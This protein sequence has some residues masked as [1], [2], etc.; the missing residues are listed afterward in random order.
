MID[1]AVIGAGAISSFHL[2]GYLAFPDRC[3]VV[4]VADTDLGRAHNR[5]AEYGLKDAV[6]FDGVDAVLASGRNIDLA[7]VCTPPSGHAEIAAKLLDAGVSTLLEK[8]MAPSLAECDA[9]L[10]AAERGGAILSVVAQNRFT[11]PMMRLKQ[12]LDSGLAGRVL[13]A[14]VDSHWWRGLSYYDLW[15][16]GTWRSEGGG[17]TL[18]HAVHHIDALQWMVGTPA[19][20]QSMIGNV[21]HGNSEVEDLSL[22][23]M[24]F[25]DGALGQLTASV[26]HHGQ[27]QQIIF[28]TERAKIAMPWTVSAQAALPNGFPEHER[29][30]A[31]ERELNDYYESLPALAYEGHTGQIDDVLTALE[32]TDGTH[33]VLVTGRDG[34]TTIEIITAIY[35]AAITAQTVTLPLPPDDPFRTRAGLLAAAP[36]FHKK[37][38]SVGEFSSNE[39]TT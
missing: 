32:T 6:A 17:C 34:R 36:H 11:N 2:D 27:E 28:Q 1:V 21:N 10:A 37:T 23:I 12:V 9:I 38:A 8:P 18:N 30:E 14:Q 39:I 33:H 31:T 15:W 5:I 3:R 29:D 25:P 20:I 26:V 16:R 4:A 13:H 35:Q 7:S 19:A 22:T 24:R